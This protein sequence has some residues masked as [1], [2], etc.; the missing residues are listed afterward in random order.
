MAKRS[1][2]TGQ[3]YIKQ[4]AWYGRWRTSDGRRLNRRLG[5][6]REPGSATGLTRREVERVFRKA[7]DAEEAAPRPLLASRVTIEEAADSLRRKLAMQG[8]RKSYLEG[9]ESMQ[10]VHIVPG[11]DDAP[12]AVVERRD[13]EALAEAMLNAGKSGKAVRNVLT[14]LHSV[15]EHAID[16][17]WCAENPVRRAT[18]PRRQRAGDA[19][20]DLQF[21]T[22]D[23][24]EAVIRAIPDETVVRRPAPTRRG[25]PG[26]APPPARCARARPARADAYRRSDCSAPV[27]AL[28]PA[29]ARCRLVGPTD[30]G[31]QRLHAR[32][33]LL[34]RQVRHA[35]P[36][37]GPTADRVLA[38]LDP[39]SKRSQYTSETSLVFAQPQS[40]V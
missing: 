11:L 36:P 40:A 34:P 3:L 24:L 14:F 25:R 31:P 9:C 38:E 22:L 21:L 4:G 35:D 16:E 26:P 33:A 39:W 7:R 27:R 12:V 23:E 28:G 13:V 1:Y 8:S 37:L 5:P 6:A 18:R 30:P 20:P 2:G 32:R 19:E 29:L 15:F 17:G 10:R